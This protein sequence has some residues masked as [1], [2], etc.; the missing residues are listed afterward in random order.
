MQL[1]RLLECKPFVH[2]VFVFDGDHSI[3]HVGGQLAIFSWFL[4]AKAGVA[5]A[6]RIHL[7]A[8]AHLEA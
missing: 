4:V 5:S 6:K 2:D 3:V 7:V 8:L 1:N